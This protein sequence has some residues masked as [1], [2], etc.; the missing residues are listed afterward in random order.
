MARPGVVLPG[1]ARIAAVVKGHAIW[2][3][4][5]RDV[6]ATTE[7]PALFTGEKTAPICDRN[8]DEQAEREWVSP[9]TP[10]HVRRVHRDHA[11]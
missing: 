4:L 3:H 8:V 10:G 11:L 7:A 5:G 9:E 2:P 1:H 6:H